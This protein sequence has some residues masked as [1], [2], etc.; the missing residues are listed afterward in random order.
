[1][2]LPKI[3]LR[4]R[5]N[6]SH[7]DSRR[8][9]HQ[10]ERPKRW[11]PQTGKY[12]KQK[13]FFLHD[14]SYLCIIEYEELDSSPSATA[15]PNHFRFKEREGS[16]KQ[17]SQVFLSY[18]RA[19]K[20]EIEFLYQRLLQSGFKPWMDKA[21]LV[22]G[23]L[24]KSKIQ[25]AIKE[26]DFILA[27]L[28]KRSINKRGFLQREIKNAI[29]IWQEKLPDDIFLIPVRLEECKVPESLSD[30]QWVDIFEEDGWAQLLK[31]LQVGR[32]RRGETTES[33]HEFSEPMKCDSRNEHNEDDEEIRDGLFHRQDQFPNSPTHLQAALPIITFPDELSSF[34]SRVDKE[35]WNSLDEDGRRYLV[36]LGTKLEP[37][38]QVIPQTP[39]PLVLGF[40]SLALGSLGENF[41]QICDRFQNIDP[42]LLRLLL[43]LSA[44]KTASMLRLNAAEE[45]NV[46]VRHLLFTLNLD[47]EM[48]DCVYLEDF[49]ERY[50]LDLG[51][52]VLFEVNERITSR[53]LRRLKE[54]QVDFNL[55]YCADDFNNWTPEVKEALKD[56]VEMSKVDYPTFLRAM[57][58]RGDNP[59][60]A[61]RQIL[62]HKIDDKPLI[63]E[64]IEDRN[65]MRFLDRHWPCS[66]HGQ[67][68]GQGYIVQ[69]GHPWDAWTLDLR[70]F[71][72]PGGHIL[73]EL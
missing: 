33:L 10:E 53:Y 11:M 51:R 35:L 3:G 29:D 12:M 15:P 7:F 55:R 38:V 31:A 6:D 42:G 18:V 59:S 66:S 24:W 63:V 37:I 67:L 21:D 52:N 34:V 26:S 22:P 70:D 65:Y 68:F 71:G 17:I 73:A 32:A 8:E 50:S 64:G 1:M 28:S 43:T 30:L 25:N 13:G 72:L 56:R 23:E 44:M 39:V 40:E 14:H 19:D 47:P 49:L 62:A 9:G 5:R 45:G 60:D 54:L 69:P 16:V 41:Q 58:I 20:Q 61:I 48:L 2:G 57:A 46:G 4:M 36:T 27:C